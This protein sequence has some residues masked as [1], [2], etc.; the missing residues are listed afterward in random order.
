MHEELLPPPSLGSSP[1]RSI[2]PVPV[3]VFQGI[4]HPDPAFREWI[5]II[6]PC[7][8]RPFSVPYL[9]AVRYETPSDPVI[10]RVDVALVPGVYA[11]PN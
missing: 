4:A 2:F 3:P 10:V 1:A 6:T 7:P 9:Q 11:P 5:V 8:S